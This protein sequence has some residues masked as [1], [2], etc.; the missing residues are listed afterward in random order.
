MRLIY[1]PA[2]LT[3]KLLCT[4]LPFSI[5]G[6]AAPGDSWNE[7]LV[8]QMRD[9]NG[10]KQVNKCEFQFSHTDEGGGLTTTLYLD[11][12]SYRKRDTRFTRKELK[13]FLYLEERVSV[14]QPTRKRVSVRDGDKNTR[15]LEEAENFPCVKRSY[16]KGGAL[17]PIE[18][19]V[20]YRVGHSEPARNHFC[21]LEFSWG[22]F[23]EELNWIDEAERR[24]R[25]AEALAAEEARLEEE[26]RRIAV[27]KRRR[28]NR[29]K[30]DQ[31][32]RKRAE[33]AAQR[34]EELA[35][36]IEPVSSTHAAGPS[37]HAYRSQH[38]G[39]R[40]GR[41]GYGFRI[42]PEMRASMERG[43]WRQGSEPVDDAESPLP[44][45]SSPNPSLTLQSPRESGHGEA[46]SPSM[47]VVSPSLISGPPPGFEPTSMGGN[48]SSYAQ[49]ALQTQPTS[50][51]KYGPSGSPLLRQVGVQS[52]RLNR[53]NGLLPDGAER[54]MAGGYAAPKSPP[55]SL[56]FPG[57]DIWG[58]KQGDGWPKNN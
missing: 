37:R 28:E 32:R 30:R 58:P 3:M 6:L 9:E 36:L 12:G 41:G 57:H 54:Y 20:S 2:C 46:E 24:E 33:S 25:E 39:G 11:L 47:S 35:G 56:L 53:A 8:I 14:C 44:G 18:I 13:A 43:S 1:K 45:L 52:M 19:C 29:R 31:L 17:E 50:P 5:V 21:R 16:Q 27:E 55:E 22:K 48:A 26:R 42:S 23:A 7:P 51:V 40:G 34:R 4:T 15:R 10:I 49:P 38:A